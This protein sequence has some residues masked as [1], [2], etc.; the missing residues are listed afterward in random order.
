MSLDWQT[1]NHIVQRTFRIVDLAPNDDIIRGRTFEDC[2][3]YGPAVLLPLDNVT[4]ED[5]TFEADLEAFFWELPEE[6]THVL[7]AVGLSECVFRRCI[8][9]RIGLA[10]TR[11]F[12]VSF[13]DDAES[14]G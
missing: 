6:R 2:T 10:G 3:I 9:R 13:V 5:N 7:G 12:I 11:N 14:T 8:F 4:L 1:D